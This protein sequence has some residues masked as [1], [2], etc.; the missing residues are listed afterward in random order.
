MYEASMQVSGSNSSWIA[1]NF[2]GF[3]YHSLG[4]PKYTNDYP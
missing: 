1:A 2:S 3:I 4:I